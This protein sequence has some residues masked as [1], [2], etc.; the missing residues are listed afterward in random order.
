MEWARILAYI[1]GTADQEL[2]LRNEYLA[3]EKWDPEGPHVRPTDSSKPS[4]DRSKPTSAKHADTPA[5]RP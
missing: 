2:L 4:M 1:S 5:S 3:A